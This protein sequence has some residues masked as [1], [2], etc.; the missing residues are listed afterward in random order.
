MNQIRGYTLIEL[1]VGFLIGTVMILM[2]GS[3]LK[4]G[5]LSYRGLSDKTQ[6]VNDVAYG[7]K[8]MRH[9]IRE[10]ASLSSD[11]PEDPVWKGSRLLVDNTAF[12]ILR[13]TGKEEFVY[14][15][16]KTDVNTRRV[17]VSMPEGNGLAF[18]IYDQDGQ[19]VRVE[20]SWTQEGKTSNMQTIVARRVE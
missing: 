7:L 20:L 6:T 9:E 3:I 2:I 14:L 4:I 19:S 16:D 10:A 5:N 17:L 1:L 8:F 12:G 13:T 18:Q 15:P 11:A